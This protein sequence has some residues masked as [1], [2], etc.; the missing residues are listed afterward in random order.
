M[1]VDPNCDG[2]VSGGSPLSSKLQ[3]E[4]GACHQET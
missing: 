3:N 1:G 2:D 4:S